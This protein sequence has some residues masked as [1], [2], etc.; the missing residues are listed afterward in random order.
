MST[1][2]VTPP[3]QPD[4]SVPALDKGITARTEPSKPN[5]LLLTRKAQ[6]TAVTQQPERKQSA[7]ARSQPETDSSQGAMG[8]GFW[9]GFGALAAGAAIVA[10]VAAVVT[11]ISEDRAEETPSPPATGPSGEKA[12]LPLPPALLTNIRDLVTLLKDL[13]E[14]SVYSLLAHLSRASA[15]RPFNFDAFLYRHGI[16]PERA[17]RTAA[18]LGGRSSPAGAGRGRPSGGGEPPSGGGGPPSGDPPGGGGQPPDDPERGKVVFADMLSRFRGRICGATGFNYCEKRK[19][20]SSPTALMNALATFVVS[21]IPTVGG[22]A[23]TMTATPVVFGGATFTAF[24]A[25]GV[26][27]GTAL[28]PIL[29]GVSVAV[30]IVKFALDRVCQCPK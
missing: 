6:R 18:N 2:I 21:I 22:G 9:L 10:A 30:L 5:P 17:H 12:T 19:A 24:A 15:G 11:A 28:A 23:A 27:A 20:L 29:A 14:E 8:W 7:P 4:P 3:P 1:K 13:D 16:A 26:S 25:T